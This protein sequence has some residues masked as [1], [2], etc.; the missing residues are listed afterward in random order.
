MG[1]SLKSLG[2][3]VYE[4]DVPVGPSS[5]IR[6]RYVNPRAAAYQKRV[7]DG[8]VCRSSD[9]SVTNS[10]TKQRYRPVAPAPAASVEP[11]LSKGIGYGHATANELDTGHRVELRPKSQLS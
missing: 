6:G 9:S 11:K 8:V 4:R 2:D 1:S 10:K 7:I 3:R 5:G